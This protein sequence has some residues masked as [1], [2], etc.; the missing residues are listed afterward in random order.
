MSRNKKD[1]KD[2]NLIKG[3]RSFYYTLLICLTV[4]MLAIALLIVAFNRL[5][6]RHDQHLSEEICTIM[7]EKMN[8][9]IDFMTQSTQ[10][11]ASVLS[12]QTF[13]SMK[14][15]KDTKRPIT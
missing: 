6:S 5:I 4:F 1:E 2:I 15:S 14:H 3:G 9:S 12:A 11:M 8:S 10:S 13:S 7:S